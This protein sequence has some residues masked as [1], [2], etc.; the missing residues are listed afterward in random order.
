MT[1]RF[2]LN[3]DLHEKSTLL[4][5]IVWFLLKK[6]ARITYGD[7]WLVVIDG[8]DGYWLEVYGQGRYQK[9]SR[10]LYS[11][12]DFYSAFITMLQFGDVATG[13]GGEDE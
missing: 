13:N 12:M 11:G 8:D 1:E 6:D 10:V 7:T 3:M 9:M 4:D 2:V 5:D